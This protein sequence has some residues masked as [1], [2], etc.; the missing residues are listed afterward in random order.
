MAGLVYP[1]S[2]RTKSEKVELS[3]P[4]AGTDFA[5]MHEPSHPRTRLMHTHSPA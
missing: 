4:G 3:V 1:E 2:L 5:T